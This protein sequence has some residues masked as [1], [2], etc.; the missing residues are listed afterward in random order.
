[1]MA[2]TPPPR[3]RA[4]FETVDVYK[5]VQTLEAL[6]ER[7]GIPVQDWVKLN[8]NENP[9][10]PAPEAKA[11]IRDI[12]LNR[13]PDSASA[14]LREAL[15]EYCGVAA[16]RIVTGNGGD[17]VIDAIFRLF[18]DPGDEAINSPPT[19]GFYPVVSKLNRARLVN[20][21]RD[22][23]FC[24][25]VK[26][27]ERAVSNRTKLILVC[28]PNNPTANLTTESDLV[29]LL[30]IGIPVLVDEAYV[31]FAGTTILPLQ[32]R[33]PHMM[34]IRTFSKW[35]GLAGLRVGYG[36]FSAPLASKVRAI[37]PAYTVNAAADAAAMASLAHRQGLLRTVEAIRRS[38]A[39]LV[40]AL[41]STTL[42]RAWPSDTNF[43][44]CTA[45]AAASIANVYEELLKRG[46]LVRL[47][48][49]PDAVRITVGTD[50][51]NARLLEALS[52]IR[53]AH[54]AARH[55][56][57]ESMFHVKQSDFSGA[58]VEPAGDG[59]HSLQAK[60]TE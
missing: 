49:N 54:E 53:D 26:G 31:E 16:E 47:F 19:F 42:M 60:R 40:E 43:V 27:V 56:P 39:R 3:F 12:S 17:E 25:D 23:R 10:G 58:T 51:E 5:V 50:A 11:A 6:S 28:S 33:Y 34:V 35:A 7:F 8:Q 44:Y 57:A 29:Q 15:A 37:R 41:G 52:E 46:I 59:T 45:G 30:E 55:A 32:E 22:S 38:R 14:D 9:Y 21:P 20:V 18:I 36:I 24:I 1:M 13:Y 2:M 4:D 48:A